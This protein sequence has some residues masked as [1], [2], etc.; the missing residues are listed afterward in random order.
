MTLKKAIPGTKV[1][2]DVEKLYNA[3]F[4]AD[5]Q[6]P[7]GRLTLLSLLK[8][9]VQ[10]LGYYDGETFCGFSFS[11]F[12]GRHLYI[13]FVGVEAGLRSK[14]YGGMILGALREK[15]PVPV[16]CEVKVPDPENDTYTQDEKR[17]AFWKRN[18]FNFFDGKYTITNH[19]GVKYYIC[20]TESEYDRD[21]YWAAFDHM[22][23]GP[24]AQLRI[25]K[26]RL[27]K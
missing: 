7:F 18:G 17:I 20:A 13:N 24:G 2:R 1:Y 12:T 16:I 6:L 5:E 25:L 22:S 27:G 10:M 15:Y 4:P 3:A 23:F 11:V 8:P 9:S 14:G 21:G 19:H 26:R